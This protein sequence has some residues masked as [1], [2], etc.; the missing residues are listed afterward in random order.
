MTTVR[1]FFPAYVRTPYFS[2]YGC[3]K[4]IFFYLWQHIAT[5]KKQRKQMDHR[6]TLLQK[7][8]EKRCRYNGGPDR[9]IGRWKVIDIHEIPASIEEHH[10]IDFYCSPGHSMLLLRLRNRENQR[11][12][13]CQDDDF[14]TYWIAE[15]PLTKIDDTLIGFLLEKFTR[16]EK[17]TEWKRY[18]A[19]SKE[20]QI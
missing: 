12:I 14:P 3:R 4:R 16:K 7:D 1:P 8:F 17:D 10:E 18:H 15:L 5:T 20:N 6:D 2:C 13:I 11:F 19:H 9:V